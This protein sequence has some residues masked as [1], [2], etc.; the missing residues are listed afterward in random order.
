MAVNKIQTPL[1]YQ[2]SNNYAFATTQPTHSLS[3][4]T[5]Y[6]QQDIGQGDL[7]Y[8]N[9]NCIITQ[10]ETIVFITQDGEYLIPQSPDGYYF[11]SQQNVAEGSYHLITQQDIYI[12]QT[13]AVDMALSYDGGAVFGNEWRYQLP[14]IGKRKNRLLWWQCGS[15][16]DIVPMF[17]FWGI[18]RFTCT[19]GVAHIRE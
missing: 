4:E 16:N 18:G 13:P 8:Q 2:P 9:G 1:L 7:I 15:S 12:N 14:A 3:G 6:Y 19:D 10:G 11:E 5:N 17:T